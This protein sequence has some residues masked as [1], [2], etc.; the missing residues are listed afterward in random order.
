MILDELGEPQT[1]EENL[2]VLERS[3]GRERGALAMIAIGAAL[4]VGFFVTGTAS[5]LLGLLL[6]AAGFALRSDVAQSFGVSKRQSRVRLDATG[7]TLDGALALGRDAIADGIF[8][9]RSPEMDGD[10]RS[11]VRL[12]DRRRRIVFE[13]EVASEEQAIAALRTFGLDAT[14][15]RMDFRAGSPMFAT[16]ARTMLSLVGLCFCVFGL[17][18]LLE[19]FGI[20][21]S[22]ALALLP[23]LPPFVATTMGARIVVGSDGISVRWYLRTRFIPIAEIASVSLRGEREI[24]LALVS[25]KREILYTSNKLR[26]DLGKDLHDVQRRDATFARI[27]EALDAYR[28]RGPAADVA[29]LVA[30]GGRSHDA[31][32]R[33]LEAMT[34]ADRGY[35]H[36]AVRAEDLWRV[37]EDPS[38]VVDARAGAAVVL[39]R[40]LDE[41]VQARIRIAAEAAASPQLR[42]ALDAVADDPDEALESAFAALGAAQPPA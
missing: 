22:P 11:S 13:A 5:A 32:R 35:R 2:V 14:R 24:E 4:V 6:A 30:R 38:A 41:G 33:A 12:Y 28:A 40:S 15:K 7:V 26:N 25:E 19:A 3:R 17:R 23:L 9:P 39:R 21:V 27:A 18:A 1:F 16:S 37:V 29:V 8:Q 42:I 10:L 31:W 20:W 34:T 36:T